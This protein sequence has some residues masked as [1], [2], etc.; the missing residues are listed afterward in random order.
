MVPDGYHC[1]PAQLALPHVRSVAT[2]RRLM[3]L[4]DSAGS[5]GVASASGRYA[6][7]CDPNLPAEATDPAA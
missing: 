7:L 1:R 6:P 3:P 2:K 4:S 5:V